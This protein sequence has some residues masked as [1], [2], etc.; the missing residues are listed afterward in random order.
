[1][2]A[3][4]A[5]KK[6]TLRFPEI[7]VSILNFV[8]MKLKNGRHEIGWRSAGLLKRL[9]MAIKRIQKLMNS[10]LKYPLHYSANAANGGWLTAI[11]YRV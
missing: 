1:M 7:V 9:F 4:S 8:S 2:A 11:L 6:S 3:F 10:M 5:L